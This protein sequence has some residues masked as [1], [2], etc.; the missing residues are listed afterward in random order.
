MSKLDAESIN[1]AVKDIRD[2]RS[3][4]TS[5][6][7]VVVLAELSAESLQN[8]YRTLDNT[9]YKEMKSASDHL[10]KVKR[11]VAKLKTADGGASR[12]SRAIGELQE[13]VSTTENATDNIMEQAEEILGLS[14]DP[15]NPGLYQ[16][17]VTNHVTSIFEAC[18]F[19][20]LTGQRVQRVVAALEKVEERLNQINEV[21]NLKRL[22]NAD[23]SIM[24]SESSKEKRQRENLLHGPQDAGEGIGQSFVD[25]IFAIE[26]KRNTA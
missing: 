3:N 26:T 7:D 11:D 24:S 2:R 5:I 20:D 6:E 9:I 21:L 22:N 23:Y 12:L 10:V 8:F 13:V 1:R 18:S 14:M 17:E 19:Q 25:A 15:E 16:M 4:G